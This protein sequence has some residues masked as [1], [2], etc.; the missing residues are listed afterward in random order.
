MGHRIELGEIEV[1][2]SS[3]NGVD[4]N[5]CIYDSNRKRIIVFYTGTIDEEALDEKL[6]DLL[7]VYMCPNKR[8]HLSNM[9]HN[10][11]GKIDR[12]KLRDEIGEQFGGHF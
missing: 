7:P 12:A 6:K 4:E 9:P 3:V 10:L 5:C 8:I 11:N 2:I 1:N